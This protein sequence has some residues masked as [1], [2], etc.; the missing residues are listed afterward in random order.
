MHQPDG[1]APQQRYTLLMVSIAVAMFMTSLDGT[2]VNIALPTIS[3]I[4]DLPSTTV[5]WVATA[6][7][8]VLTGSILVFGK[9]ADRIGFKTVFLAGFCVFTASSFFCGFFP[10]LFD[11]FWVLIG[12]RVLQAIGGAM[13]AAIAPALIAAFLPMTMKG[14]AMGIVTTFAAFG[15]AAGPI[16]GGL[17][18]QYLSWNWI[19]YINVPVGIVAVLL[20]SYAIPAGRTA[21]GAPSPFDRLGAVL[22]FVGLGSLIY[23][24]SE[25]SALGWTDPAILA[26]LAAAGIALG[27]LVLHERRTADPLLDFRLFANRNFLYVNL[28]LALSYFLFGGVNY[29]LPFF[30]ELVK[31]FDPS[32][33]G[34]VL[35]ALS[36]AMMAS[37]ILSGMLINSLGNRRLCIAGALVVS[38]GYLLFHLFSAASTLHYIIGTFAIVG[39]GLGFLLSPGTNMA[40]NMAPR[41]KHGMVSSLISVERSGPITLGISFAS[42]LFIQAMLTV[43]SHRHVTASSPANIKIDVLATGFDLVFIAIFAVS[44]AVVV[45]AV[46]SRDEVHADNLEEGA[47]EA[48]VA[49]V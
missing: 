15:T 10:E 39:F 34:L 38:A 16:L 42:M 2:I 9:V 4:F 24:V 49:G 20:G 33:S 45:L 47:F 17:L 41:D 35:T 1:S 11:S 3:T 36:F 32:T 18:T 21:G 23:A 27:Y 19:F 25:G 29:L 48:A 30:L 43:G 7:L 37:G 12:A 31:G 44:L 40:M 46:L 6:Y 22:I 28:M 14:K 5:S 26:A 13:I 8:L